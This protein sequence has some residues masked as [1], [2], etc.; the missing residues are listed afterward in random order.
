MFQRITESAVEE[1]YHMTTEGED[2]DNRQYDEHRTERLPW[3]RPLIENESNPEA[4]V[5][6]WKER[7]KGEWRI[8]LWLHKRSYLLVVAQRGSE[9]NRSYLP[10]TAFAIEYDHQQKKYE[11]RWKRHSQK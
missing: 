1:S 2:E 9:T 11:K 10:W 6:V 5:R 8:H 7:L 4:E 3:A